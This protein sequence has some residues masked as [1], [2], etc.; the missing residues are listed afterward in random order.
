MLFFKDSF[1]LY[2][3]DE[4]TSRL[5]E[6]IHGGWMGSRGELFVRGATSIIM[7]FS[8]ARASAGSVI[9]WSG[10]TM[11]VPADSL[12]ERVLRNGRV[13][14]A[15]AGDWQASAWDRHR[16]SFSD[17]GFDVVGFRVLKLVGLRSKY[18]MTVRDGIYWRSW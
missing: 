4:N 14:V 3:Y 15:C 12:A 2:R 18:G 5:E 11:P 9:P 17:S 8:E 1:Q 13:E 10:G 6:A 7:M 16:S